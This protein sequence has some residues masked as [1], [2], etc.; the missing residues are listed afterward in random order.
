MSHT[1][2]KVLGSISLLAVALFTLG[3]VAQ[4][5]LDLQFEQMDPHVGQALFLR[6]IDS[7]S[8]EEIARIEGQEIVAGAFSIELGGLVVGSSYRIELF[9]D[10]DGNGLY[11]APPVDHAW[12]IELPEVQADGALTFVHST[13]FT[14]IGWPPLLDG[15][16]A[17]GE[18]GQM[19]SD[20][21]TGMEVYSYVLG[22]L[23]YIGL[24]APGT[25]WL[26]IGFEPER[27]MQGANIII[28]GIDE[29]GLVIEDHYGSSPTAHRIDDVDHIIQAAGSESEETS[30]LE[31]VIP[32]DSGDDQ[33]KA[34]EAGSEATII[35][36][37]HSSN[38]RLTM[39][40]TKRS[41][42]TLPLGE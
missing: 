42:T 21:G 38:D 9:A 23:L 19:I 34:L 17:E 16:I 31:F 35:L 1:K 27:M 28:A 29:D 26:S 25:G 33:D 7:A 13:M 41:T 20:T 39:R 30:V 8:L 18:Y 10:V 3:T 11:D 2:R 6:V 22:D 40:H 4:V 37:Y 14:D 32:L 12:R 24:I 15:L 36:A 5:S